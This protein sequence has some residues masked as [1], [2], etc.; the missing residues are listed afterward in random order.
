MWLA[1]PEDIPKWVAPV[2]PPLLWFWH[3]LFKGLKQAITREGAKMWRAPM[4]HLA[5]TTLKPKPESLKSLGKRKQLCRFSRWTKIIIIINGGKV[6]F[7]WKVGS[8]WLRFLSAWWFSEEIAKHDNCLAKKKLSGIVIHRFVHLRFAR[9]V[10]KRDT[11]TFSE[12]AN[13]INQ[14][15]ASQGPWD[16]LYPSS[17]DCN[18]F[19]KLANRSW[20]PEGFHP[21]LQ[22]VP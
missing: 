5:Q 15:L 22:P 14:S 11:N 19:R 8:G 7:F 6:V 20:T 2:K 9:W 17:I 3:I 10:R 12:P 13:K 21:E 16:T 18:I 4:G 1:F